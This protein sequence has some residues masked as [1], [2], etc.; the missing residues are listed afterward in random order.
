M[1]FYAQGRRI[2]VSGTAWHSQG[3]DGLIKPPGPPCCCYSGASWSSSAWASSASTPRTTSGRCVAKSAT[4]CRR[5]MAFVEPCNHACRRRMGGE[6]ENVQGMALKR[7]RE[8]EAGLQVEARARSDVFRPHDLRRDGILPDARQAIDEDP[9][10]AA[11]DKCS[12]APFDLVVP[13]DQDPLLRV[14][15]AHL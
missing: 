11:V 4:S 5:R 1:N 12:R 2:L 15:D 13:A 10:C 7:R 3:A 6:S 9:R 8:R 14:R